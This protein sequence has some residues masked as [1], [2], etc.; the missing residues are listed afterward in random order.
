MPYYIFKNIVHKKHRH[1]LNNGGTSL[2]LK[3]VSH[4][5]I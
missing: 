4:F 5:C 1:M 2:L 3:H